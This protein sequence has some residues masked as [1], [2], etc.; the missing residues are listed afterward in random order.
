M[1]YA[2]L[3]IPIAIILLVA[4]TFPLFQDPRLDIRSLWKIDWQAIGSLI[5]AAGVLAAAY[6]AW[7]AKRAAEAVLQ[8]DR[9]QAAREQEASAG[10]ARSLALAL[11]LEI[12]WLRNGLRTFAKSLRQIDD[13]SKYKAEVKLFIDGG[14]PDISHEFLWRAADSASDFG[15]PLAENILF[16]LKAVIS[17]GNLRQVLRAA[18]DP[19]DRT[20]TSNVAARCDSVDAA[21]VTLQTKLKESGLLK[22]EYAS[23]DLQASGP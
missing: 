3:F 16:A 4:T 8:V 11:H 22:A 21:L 1:T 10:R 7:M 5:G 12:L 14:F 15:M 17:V 13:E 6:A 19:Y 9:N 18:T 23:V 20:L 2:R